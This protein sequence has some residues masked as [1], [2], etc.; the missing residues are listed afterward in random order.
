M[1][2]QSKSL[3]AYGFFGEVLYTAENAPYLKTHAITHIA[4]DDATR[5]LLTNPAKYNRKGG[6]IFVT[7]E[8][9]RDDF[10]RIFSTTINAW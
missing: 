7:F 8:A 10:M 3:S 4:W 9:C 2:L 1:H 5:R 6:Q